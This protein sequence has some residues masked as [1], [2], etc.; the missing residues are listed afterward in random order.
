[1]EQET[2]QL[3]LDLAWPG[4]AASEELV[5]IDEAQAAP[6][7]FPRLRGAIDAD[8]RNNGR[9][10]LLGSISPALMRHVS[11]ESCGLSQRSSP[12]ARAALTCPA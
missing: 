11:E 8:R 4:A 12:P 1:M 10:L 2:D 5:I 6:E 9:F 3:R 7:I